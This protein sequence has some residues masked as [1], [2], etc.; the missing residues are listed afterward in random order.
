MPASESWRLFA[1]ILLPETILSQLEAWQRKAALGVG[2]GWAWSPRTQ[3]HLTLRFL[4]SQNRSQVPELAGR[5]TDAAAEFAP[6]ELALDRPGVFPGPSRP[7]VL[8]I[9][10]AGEVNRLGE[11]QQRVEETSVVLAPA[12]ARA[13]HPHLTLARRLRTASRPPPSL[14][15]ALGQPPRWPAPAFRVEAFH[16][17]RSH[18]RPSGAVYEVLYRFELGGTGSPIQPV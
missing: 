18:L 10:V 13:Y 15:E 8:W 2:S 1:A 16:L 3:W 14:M 7:K 17:M 6:M 5:W 12:E 9:G 4:G 11:L